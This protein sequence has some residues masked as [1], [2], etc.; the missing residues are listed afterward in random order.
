MPPLLS[1][2]PRTQKAYIKIPKSSPITATLLSPKITTTKA[3]P[4]PYTFTL[5]THK[6]HSTS[7]QGFFFF[8]KH[9]VARSHRR[10][11]TQSA[12]QKDQGMYKHMDPIKP[13]QTGLPD[14]S[15]IITTWH[16]LKV[17][18]STIGPKIY[19]PHYTAWTN[20]PNKVPQQTGPKRP[21]EA[22]STRTKKRAPDHPFSR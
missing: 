4:F 19:P 22:H 2:P 7:V 17:H 21:K 8:N 11:L 14:K 6:T 10:R 13:H 15:Q 16:G 20:K 1:Q 3:N 12:Q 9:H 18:C 5:F